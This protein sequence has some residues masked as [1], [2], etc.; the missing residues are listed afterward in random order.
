MV[1]SLKQV[2]RHYSA[3]F[4]SCI[5]LA[6]LVALFSQL[7]IVIGRNYDISAHGFTIN[8]IMWYIAI[9]ELVVLTAIR[10]F[11]IIENDIRS[12]DI[13][14]TMTRPL[15]YF[16]M[17]QSEGWGQVLFRFPI[18][19]CV[20][21]GTAYLFSGEWIIPIPLM[22]P[23]LLFTLCSIFLL[24]LWY[25][26]IGL[27]AFWLQEASAPYF[28]FSKL[29]F[30]FGG[31]YLPIDFFPEWLH[32]ISVNTPFAVIL[33]APAHFALNPTWDSA[34]FWGVRMVFWIGFTLILNLIIMHKATK[35][36]CINGG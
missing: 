9:T 18:F 30:V 6:L 17:K 32:D 8:N 2:A 16:A 28:V 1:T 19:A 23:T 34:L 15:S 20:S 36:L 10:L 26:L 25:S 29:M 24:H 12:G 21:F 4:G 7:W 22:I 13:V 11:G 31:I 27:C 35:S 5:M 14:Y 33:Y 3:V